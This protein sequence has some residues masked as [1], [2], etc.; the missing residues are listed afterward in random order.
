MKIIFPTLLVV[1]PFILTAQTYTTSSQG[2]NNSAGGAYV[3]PVVTKTY[4]SGKS[5]STV[6]HYSS[7]NATGSINI[8][9][10]DKKDAETIQVLARGTDITDDAY[11]AE[12]IDRSNA[13]FARNGVLA[14]GKEGWKNIINGLIKSEWPAKFPPSYSFDSGYATVRHHNKYGVIDTAGN[15]IIPIIWEG[16]ASTFSNGLA[17]VNTGGRDQKCGFMNKTNTLVIPL[18]YDDFHIGFREGLAVVKQGKKWGY[19]DTDDV[20]VIPFIYDEASYFHMGFAV[21]ELK[22]KCGV[23]DKTGKQILPVKYESI[24]VDGVEKMI[25]YKNKNKWGAFNLD[26]NPVIP[27]IYNDNFDFFRGKAKVTLNSRTFYI[28]KTGTEVAAP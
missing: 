27:P 7:T 25:T 23:I 8:T 19:I 17:C 16:Y 5:P 9:V 15:I 24:T 18:K 22:K 26:G 10:F 28:D 12:I 4:S 13:E 21:V 1:F 11:Y 2:S 14:P 20:T 6:P 3:A